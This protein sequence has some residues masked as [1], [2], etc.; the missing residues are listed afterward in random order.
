MDS[1]ESFFSKI[2]LTEIKPDVRV[3]VG[4]E[5]VLISFLKE[6]SPND[7]DDVDLATCC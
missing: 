1:I 6:I 3:P 5:S 4:D 2:S 7:C